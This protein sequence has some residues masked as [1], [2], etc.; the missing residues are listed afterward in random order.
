[1]HQTGSLDQVAGLVTA[2]RTLGEGK[3]VAAMCRELTAA[4]LADLLAL[5]IVTAPTGRV[6]PNATGRRIWPSGDCRAMRLLKRTLNRQV[7][8]TRETVYPATFSE[9][10]KMGNL[11]ERCA[12][13][14]VV[15]C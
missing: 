5:D 8:T 3:D 15:A 14:A 9:H 6:T 2:D 7:P 1:M 12:Y 10:C 4:V 13:C 11:D